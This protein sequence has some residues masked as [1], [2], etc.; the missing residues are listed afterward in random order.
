VPMLSERTLTGLAAL[1]AA[2]GIVTMRR[3]RA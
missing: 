3:R 1:L 2:K